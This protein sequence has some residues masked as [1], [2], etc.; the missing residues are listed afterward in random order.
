MEPMGNYNS[1]EPP[2]NSIGNCLGLS[3]YRIL[4]GTF[5]T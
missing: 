3:P 5:L 4:F 2:K 1:K